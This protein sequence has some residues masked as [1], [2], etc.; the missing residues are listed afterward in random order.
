MIILV[1]KGSQ[2]GCYWDSVPWMMMGEFFPICA[3]GIATFTSWMG[4]FI[5]TK[6]FLPLGNLM[7]M[8]G[9]F[10]ILDGV[11]FSVIRFIH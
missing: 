10:W 8:Y 9:L 4:G 3:R 5:I 1:C 2:T 6:E 11:C 7:H